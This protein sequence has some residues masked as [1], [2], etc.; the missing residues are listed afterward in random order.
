MSKTPAPGAIPRGCDA[1]YR[2]NM[3]R[4]AKLV[5]QGDQKF[6]TARIGVNMA[7]PT[8]PPEEREKLTEWVDVI[9]F[10][11]AQQERLLAAE[12]GEPISVSGNVTLKFYKRGNGETAIGRT[13]IA[14]YIRCASASYIP[15]TAKADDGTAPDPHRPPTD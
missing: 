15:R 8:V 3:T 9:A 5:E 6:A 7:A 4:K 12:K 11:K 1:T 10:S 13:I 2:G 14:D